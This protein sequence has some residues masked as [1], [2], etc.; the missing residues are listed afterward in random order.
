[1]GQAE[2]V[3]EMDTF[4]EDFDTEFPYFDL[5]QA[6]YVAKM[7]GDLEQAQQDF[8]ELMYSMPEDHP[9]TI[10]SQWIFCYYY[11]WCCQYLFD[12]LENAIAYY[13]VIND[14]LRPKMTLAMYHLSVCLVS[15]W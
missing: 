15:K 5:A 8:K 13:R 14:A 4:K 3:K 1:M 10:S 11:A 9:L 6:Y 12:D 2:Y 7:C